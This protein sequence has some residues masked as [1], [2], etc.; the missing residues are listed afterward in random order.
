M[1]AL[2]DLTAPMSTGSPAMSQQAV[3]VNV[4]IFLAV[5]AYVL[6]RQLSTRAVTSRTFLLVA[7]LFAYGLYS[8]FPTA[9]PGIALLLASVVVSIGFGVWRGTSMRMWLASDGVVYRRGTAL[10]VTLWVITVTLKVVLDGWE[11][12]TT[13][14]F[15]VG[16]IW[17]AMAVTLAVQ[18]GV[19]LRRAKSLTPARP[20]Q[21]RTDRPSP[22]R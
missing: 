17:L 15:T 13:H 10:T 5:L 9:P 19:M 20:H 8:G 16:S 11:T 22:H 12:V 14:T 18:Q 3:A 21:P 7:I 1:T 2:T 4:A 6:Q